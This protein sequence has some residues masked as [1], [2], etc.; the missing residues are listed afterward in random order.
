MKQIGSIIT[1]KQL[2]ETAWDTGLWNYLLCVKWD[3]QLYSSH[4]LYNRRF[5]G[6]LTGCGTSS[7]RTPSCNWRGCLRSVVLCITV[8]WRCTVTGVNRVFVR[9]QLWRCLKNINKRIK[10]MTIVTKHEYN[11]MYAVQLGWLVHCEHSGAGRLATSV[12]STSPAHVTIWKLN[13]RH[14]SE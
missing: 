7:C 14:R 3:V 4:S 11:E 5:T 6:I 8:N 9:Y 1:K 12:T 2:P 10:M 13:K